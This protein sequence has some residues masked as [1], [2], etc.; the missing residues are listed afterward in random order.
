MGPA[1]RW[2]AAAAALGLAAER[3]AAWKETAAWQ[4]YAADIGRILPD[5]ESA[6][7]TLLTPDTAYGPSSIV[8][9]ILTLSL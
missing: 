2:A 8:T 6:V 3:D 7:R 5:P 4:R 1:G 9:D